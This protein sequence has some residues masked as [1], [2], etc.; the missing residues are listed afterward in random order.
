MGNGTE[1]LTERVQSQH[2]LVRLYWSLRHDLVSTWCQD[3]Q[4]WIAGFVPALV[5]AETHKISTADDTIGV[6]MRVCGAASDS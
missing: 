1:W 6:P 2:R 4:A 5:C 3:F